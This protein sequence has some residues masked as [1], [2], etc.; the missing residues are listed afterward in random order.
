M[1]KRQP[2]GIS[3]IVL[4][5]SST[6]NGPL[7]HSYIDRMM[8]K[9]ISLIETWPKYD[10]FNNSLPLPIKLELTGIK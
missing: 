5:N 6:W 10:L 2:D 8:T 9:A 1:L 4:L 7:I 3:W